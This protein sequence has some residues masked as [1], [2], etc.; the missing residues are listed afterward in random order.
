MSLYLLKADEAKLDLE[1]TALGPIWKP[2]GTVS[3]I[4]ISW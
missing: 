1:K 2:M 4:D 3:N